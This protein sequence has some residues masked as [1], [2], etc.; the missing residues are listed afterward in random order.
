MSLSWS[1]VVR[2]YWLAL[3]S[4]VKV[5]FVGSVL[6]DMRDMKIVDSQVA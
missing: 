3:N 2:W 5:T 4:S 6:A 1:N